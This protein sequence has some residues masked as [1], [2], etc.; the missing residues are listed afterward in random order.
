M[1]EYLGEG[2]IISQIEKVRLYWPTSIFLPLFTVS[3]DHD[4]RVANSLA[5]TIQIITIA[6]EN[7]NAC[8]SLYTR[9]W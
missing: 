4:T 6:R 8:C 3:D 7:D 9:V 2:P 5:V 1:R